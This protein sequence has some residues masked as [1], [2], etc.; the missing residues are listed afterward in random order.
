MYLLEQSRRH[1][2]ELAIQLTHLALGRMHRKTSVTRH[3][4]NLVDHDSGG[5][6]QRLLEV[7]AKRLLGVSPF[8]PPQL[9][10]L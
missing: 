8:G 7:G 6:L 4:A 5:P 1:L 9:R 3:I 10:M 2:G